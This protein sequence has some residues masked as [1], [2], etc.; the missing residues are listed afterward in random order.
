MAEQRKPTKAEVAAK[1]APLLAV[2]YRR[3]L[4][5]RAAEAAAARAEK[6]GEA[7]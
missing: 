1:I 5:K 4:E 7:A 6:R 2:G 3:S